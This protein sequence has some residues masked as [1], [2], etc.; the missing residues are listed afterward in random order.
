MITKL[1]LDIDLSKLFASIDCTQEGSA[2]ITAKAD[3]HYYL[4][5]D[6]KC[7]AANILKQ[8]ALSLGADL[9]VPK[10]VIL[11]KQELVNAVLIANKTQLKLL[12]K[13]CLKQPF[14]LKKLAKYLQQHL[15]T[16]KFNK[17]IMGILNVNDDSFYHA[18]CIKP[19]E[20]LSKAEQMI[21]D[22]ADVL[23]I[24]AVSSKPGAVEVSASE[25]FKRIK[26]IID[27]CYQHKIYESSQLSL[28]SHSPMVLEYALDRG[29]SIINDITGLSD[30]K[31][32]S[33]AARFNATVCI[34]HMQGTPKTMQVN[35]QYDD[36]ILDLDAFFTK[37][38]EKAK[39]FGIQKLILDVG[40]GF[41]KSLQDNLQL[42]KYQS[43][44]LKFGFALLIGA[45]R[46]GFLSK[47]SQ[48]VVQDRLAATLAVHIKALQE[49]ASI[50]RVHD[51]KAH[52]Q[53]L[54]TL[55]AIS[56]C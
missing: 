35:P 20:F 48:S 46:K 3:L 38:I 39:S 9:A 8:D 30:D 32:A 23:D 25:E 6:L 52:F 36:V 7:P 10:G 22:G 18:N 45:S 40:I 42:I 28:D 27:L 2:I 53:A 29:F 37:R 11:C 4:I 14:G 31:V 34:M 24:G 12:I 15:K 47:I 17:Q 56:Q 19:N 16:P 5:K 41:G 51:V 49:G 1:P 21:Q 44:F 26:P 43:H 50:V 33:L 54:E 13:K 55:K